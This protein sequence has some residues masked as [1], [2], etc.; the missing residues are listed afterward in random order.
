MLASRFATRVMS[1]CTRSLNDGKALH[2]AT[3]VRTGD[4][5]IF[6]LTLSQLSYRGLMH[7]RKFDAYRKHIMRS[8]QWALHQLA[9]STALIDRLAVL[10]PVFHFRRHAHAGSR[11][12]VTSM[13]GL[14]DAATL[15]APHVHG[16]YHLSNRQGHRTWQT[17]FC[18]M[19]ATRAM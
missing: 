11:A 4:L 1:T 15:H 6:G 5:Q 12:R 10:A 17:L 16:W 19:A 14:Y 8:A 18:C 13:G 2:A 7:P 3:R 9:Y